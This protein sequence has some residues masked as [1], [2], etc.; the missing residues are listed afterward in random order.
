MKKLL[1]LFLPFIIFT[2]PQ[3]LNQISKNVE[4]IEFLSKSSL[5]NYHEYRIK[6]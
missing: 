5:N 2:F 6:E 4:A 3:Y 1:L